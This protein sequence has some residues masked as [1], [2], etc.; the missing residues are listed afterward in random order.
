MITGGCLCGAVR[1]EISGEPL[2]GVHCHCRD[3]QR[4]SGTGHL[5]VMGVPKAAFR[6]TGETR[7]YATTGHSGKATIRHFCPS[8]GS[9]LFGTPEVAPDIATVYVG[10][11]DDPSVFTPQAAIFNRSRQGWDMVDAELA[12][13]ETVSSEG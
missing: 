13:Y 4:V 10:C 8:C 2:F 12:V 3:C 5:P 1:Y 11:L 6:A 7:N 9:I